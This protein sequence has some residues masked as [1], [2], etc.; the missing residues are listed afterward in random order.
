MTEYTYIGSELE[1]FSHASNWEAY[2]ARLIR[3][4]LGDEVL[5]VAR[6]SGLRRLRYAVGIETL[7]L[8]RTRPGARML[9]ARVAK[10]HLPGCCEVRVGTLSEL[11]QENM[12]DSMEHNAFAYSGLHVL[13]HGV[14]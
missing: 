4:Y 7:G 8:P 2:H 10:G 11:G 9:A 6:A 3:T 14:L 5:E 12:F 13:F 1:L